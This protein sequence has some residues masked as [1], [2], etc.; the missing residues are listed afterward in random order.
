MKLSISKSSFG[1]KPS[2]IEAI[3]YNNCD[4]GRPG[5]EQNPLLLSHRQVDF[6]LGRQQKTV[7]EIPPVPSR[8]PCQTDQITFVVFWPVPVFYCIFSQ[9]TGDS[10]LWFIR[11]RHTSINKV[12]IFSVWRSP[13]H[14]NGMLASVMFKFCRPFSGHCQAALYNNW[15]ISVRDC[16]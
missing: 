13:C 2:S 15:A 3:L 9:W 10:L 16:W 12:H 14:E 11:V 4:T 7:I 1:A 5:I 8:L 6:E